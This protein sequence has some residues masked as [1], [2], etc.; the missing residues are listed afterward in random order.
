MEELLLRIRAVLRRTQ[1]DDGDSLGQK[2]CEIGKFHFDFETRILRSKNSEQRLTTKESELLKLF[3]LNR[4]RTVQRSYAL[5]TVWGD[6]SYFNA[7]SMDVYIVKLRKILKDD[8]SVQIVT[9]HG[10]G[11]KLLAPQEENK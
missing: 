6:D 10:E 1:K 2:D 3:C 7:R 5:K 11:F 9:V 4:N 8:D